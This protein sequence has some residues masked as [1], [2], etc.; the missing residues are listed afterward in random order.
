[1][2]HRE[3]GPMMQVTIRHP[4][5]GDLKDLVEI[6]YACFPGRVRE[7]FGG[8]HRRVFIVDYLRFYLAWDPANA[9]VY[10][11]S[12]NVLGVVIAP[13]HY[14]PVRAALV[15]GQVFSWL[16][17]LLTGR[18]GIPIHILRLFVRGGFAF[19]SDAA[20]RELWGKPFIH[21]F[22]ITPS[23]QGQGIGATLLGWTLDQYRRQG[24]ECC[25]LLVQENNQR[26]ITF[27]ERFGF[28]RHKLLASGDLVMIWG[29][30]YVGTRCRER[31]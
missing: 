1:M 30:V 16:W 22:A 5:E 27:Y 18:Y 14:A 23:A 8:M 25:W 28:R 12:S 15:Q 24:V 31:R 26:A 19:N 6:Y 2:S 7:V 4:S 10:E 20:M 29:D 9:W 17:H 21:L 3:S 11:N 13:C